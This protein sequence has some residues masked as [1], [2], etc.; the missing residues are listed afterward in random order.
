MFRNDTHFSTLRFGV[1]GNNTA[2]IIKNLAGI[3]ARNSTI[4]PLAAHKKIHDVWKS[5]VPGIG[6]GVLVFDWQSDDISVPYTL[7]AL[8]ETPVDFP[9]SDER[10]VDI[11]LIL[12]SPEK[13]GP[14]HLQSLSR[15]TRMFRDP[16]LLEKLRSVSCVDGMHSVLSPEN[17]KLQAA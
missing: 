4:S 7:C 16:A 1:K 11:A 13:S 12:V 15:M 5:S 17:R 2:Q 8:L 14:L 9:T 3:V 6:D 10:P